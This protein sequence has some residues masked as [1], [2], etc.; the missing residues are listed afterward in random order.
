MD[1]IQERQGSKN[2]SS[3]LDATI[4]WLG[5]RISSVCGIRMSNDEKPKLAETLRKR[6]TVHSVQDPL[7]YFQL[8]ESPSREGV[9]EWEHLLALFLNGETHFFRDSGQMTLLKDQILPTLI[10]RRKAE[11]SLRIWSAGCSTGE[12]AYSLAI[13]VDQLLPDRQNWEI[14]ILG[15]DINRR[16][17]QHAQHGIYGQWAFRK[18]DVGLQQR[19]FQQR[20]SQW[21]LNESIRKMVTFRNSNIFTDTFSSSNLGIYDMDLIICRNVFLYFHTDA[22]DLVVKKMSQ[23]L[24]SEGYFLTGHGELPAKTLGWLQAKNFPDSVIYQRPQTMCAIS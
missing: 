9:A 5:V 15:T 18:I 3:A 1:G 14:F 11:R 7:L 23:T 8:V 24:T 22:I 12:E 10:H 4:E 20:G 21:I 17:I 13:L 19:Y 2:I 6:M 16:S